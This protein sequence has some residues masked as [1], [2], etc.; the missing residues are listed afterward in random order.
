MELRG[1]DAGKGGYA[2][3]PELEEKQEIYDERILEADEEYERSTRKGSIAPI[4]V[5]KNK[6]SLLQGSLNQNL[7]DE[8]EEEDFNYDGTPPRGSFN[9]RHS[10]SVVSIPIDSHKDGKADYDDAKMRS[11]SYAHQTM[12]K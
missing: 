1:P 12:G 2:D 8:E 4:V 10:E 9:V 3:I 11:V 5:R 6:E 7:I